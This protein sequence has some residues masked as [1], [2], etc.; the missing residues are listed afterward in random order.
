MKWMEARYRT[1]R[2]VPNMLHHDAASEARGTA[3]WPAA[4]VVF[5]SNRRPDPTRLLLIW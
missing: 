2:A 4:A 1:L 3:D 5:A